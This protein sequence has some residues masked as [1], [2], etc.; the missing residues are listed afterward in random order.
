MK[1][2]DRVKITFGTSGWRGI[3]ADDF[4]FEHVRIVSQ[5][6]A[7][8]V[9]S[10]KHP[11]IMIGY[12]SRF[13]AEDFSRV[14]AEVLTGNEIK[15]FLC[16]TPTPTPVISYTI[17]DRQLAGGINITASH[18]P[19][20]YSGIKFNPESG[21]PALPEI[22]KAIEQEIERIQHGRKPIRRERLQ[23]ASRMGLFESIDPRQPYFEAIRKKIDFERIRSIDL[24]VTMDL[25]YGA[26]NNYLDVLV[27]EALG[28]RTKE[29][30]IAI[31]DFRDPYFGGYRPEPDLKRMEELGK[32]VVQKGH[33][34]GIALD[35]DADRFGICDEDGDFIQ[36]NEYLALVAWH[37]YKNKGLKGDIARS[38]ATSHQMDR[39]AEA[40]GGKAIVTPVGFKYI[41]DRIVTDNLVLGGEESGGLSI[42]GH[43]PEKDGILACMLALEMIAYEQKPLSQIREEVREVSGTFYSERKD[44]HLESNA[45]KAELMDFFREMPEFAGH[46]FSEQW[47][48]DGFGY[49]L[50]TEDQNSWI[51]ARASGTE[52]VVRIYIESTSDTLFEKMLAEV[53]RII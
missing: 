21:G 39:V 1:K 3:I 33:H 15:V 35:G 38:I 17:I 42:Q 28:E 16:E 46:G 4:T 11:Q 10:S 8:V 26:G 51:L 30:L 29:E 32:R 52:P 22:T 5:A 34:L 2:E 31:H 53:D 23:E 19:A 27:K 9:K 14:I 50:N 43:V 24:R 45:Q 18:N 7:E 48:T 20:H 6:I 44:L 12:D 41:G 47:T 13:M 36:P 49:L 37:L 40:Y 25:M